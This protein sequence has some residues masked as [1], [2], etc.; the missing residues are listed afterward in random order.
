MN[1]QKLPNPDQAT[2][3]AQ[4]LVVTG[5]IVE[6]FVFTNLTH[7]FHQVGRYASCIIAHN[8]IIVTQT[9]T[10]YFQYKSIYYR[11]TIMRYGI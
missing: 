5:I 8:V 11:I 3:F 7:R 1:P 4:F 10:I 6:V 2:G 9:E